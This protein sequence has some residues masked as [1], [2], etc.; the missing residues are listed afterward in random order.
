MICE[1]NEWIDIIENYKLI[2]S[3]SGEITIHINIKHW[4]NTVAWSR[5][6][7]LFQAS[8]SKLPTT[9]TRD[10]WERE[11]GGR[12]HHPP[13]TTTTLTTT[14]N[15]TLHSPIQLPSQSHTPTEHTAQ[16]S[17]PQ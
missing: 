1:L 15:N 17:R 5:F 7:E 10:G 6:K 11:F 12:K 13:P 16:L 8:K 9:P 14:H 2:E 4:S 3:D